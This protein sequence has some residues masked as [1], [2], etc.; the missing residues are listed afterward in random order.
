MVILS[1]ISETRSAMLSISTWFP[2]ALWAVSII[3]GFFLGKAL[4]GALEKKFSSSMYVDILRHPVLKEMTNRGWEPIKSGRS[5]VVF[6]KSR[7]IVGLGTAVPSD[8]D[9]D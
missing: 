2:F 6:S 3:V 9:I 4:S 7:R 8:E 1:M 5:R